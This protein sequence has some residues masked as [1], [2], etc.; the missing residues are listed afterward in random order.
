MKDLLGPHFPSSASCTQ[1]KEA[2]PSASNISP[3][4]SS[5]GFDGSFSSSIASPFSFLPTS[6]SPST[7]SSTTFSSSSSAQFSFNF[8]TAPPLGATSFSF[9]LPTTTPAQTTIPARSQASGFSFA[10]RLDSASTIEENSASVPS[11][12][13]FGGNPSSS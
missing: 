13:V 1:R 2:S 6:S 9:N 5:S 12:F 10:M 11:T 7:P 8:P 3:S 4:P